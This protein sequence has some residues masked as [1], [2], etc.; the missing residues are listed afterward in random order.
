MKWVPRGTRTLMGREP[1]MPPLHMQIPMQLGMPVFTTEVHLSWSVF[2][3]IFTIFSQ[4]ESLLRKLNI[5]QLS[6]CRKRSVYI[7]VTII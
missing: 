3:F 4:I 5:R 7:T 6:V 1:L 2:S